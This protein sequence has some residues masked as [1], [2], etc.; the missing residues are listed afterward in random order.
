MNL[1]PVKSWTE[2]SKHHI[3]GA[4][5]IYVGSWLAGYALPEPNELEE[6]FTFNSH[7]E[8][9]CK[10]IQKRSPVNLQGILDHVE[11]S[12]KEFLVKIAG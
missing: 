8:Q 5:R 3:P 4:L 10:C 1:R 2:K 11:L 9:I 6:L 12:Y 7:H